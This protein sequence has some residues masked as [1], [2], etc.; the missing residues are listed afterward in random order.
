PGGGPAVP[1]EVA[2]PA[3]PYRRAGDARRCGDGGRL[4]RLAPACLADRRLG[5]GPVT[6]ARCAR[7]VRGADRG[8]G[9]ALCWRRCAAPAA[10]VRLPPRP[11]RHR[12]LAGP[13]LP[14]ARAPPLRNG[15]RERLARA[16]AVPM[17]RA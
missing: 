16:D 10:L 7:D 8:S 12:I 13:P 17:S 6:S 1:L 3:G 5:L 11:A 4:F 14:P 2:A 15:W 9:G